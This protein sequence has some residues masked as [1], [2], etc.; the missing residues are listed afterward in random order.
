MD[1]VDI[2][3]ES[4]LLVH[5]TGASLAIAA[6]IAYI[7]IELIVFKQI[8]PTPRSAETQRKQRPTDLRLRW[9]APLVVRPH[10]S[11]L[12]LKVFLRS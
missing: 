1:E 10:L 11:T 9:F 7:N 5:R 2:L 4:S 6:E 12:D 3:R 8:W